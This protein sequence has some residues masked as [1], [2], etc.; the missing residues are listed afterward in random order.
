[1]TLAFLAVSSKTRCLERDF[2]YH[3]K[4]NTI[5][6]KLLLKVSVQN[7]GGES[8]N[9]TN[10]CSN[11]G[12]F[13]CSPPLKN[14]LNFFNKK[15]IHMPMTILWYV[16]DDHDH[17]VQSSALFLLSLRQYFKPMDGLP[18]LPRDLY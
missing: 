6:N 17:T 9:A 10:M 3:V 13:R 1:M 7:K 11:F 16:F 5:S 4:A 12:G 14:A 8:C 18:N 15:K 2:R